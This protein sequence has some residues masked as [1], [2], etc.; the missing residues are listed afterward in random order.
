MSV[1]TMPCVTNRAVLF[2]LMAKDWRTF[3]VPVIAL[4][5]LGLGAYGYGL[6]TIYSSYKDAPYVP[7][8]SWCMAVISSTFLAT[9]ISALIAAAFGG[10]AI[11]GER[12]DRT[13][14]FVEILPVSRRQIVASKW[15]VTLM[16][17]I[18]TLALHLF[19]GLIAYVFYLRSIRFEYHAPTS[20]MPTQM[21]LFWFVPLLL[22]P[23]ILC[24]FSV[25]WLLGSFIKSAA[26]S[27]CVSIATTIAGC[28]FA[29]QFLFKQ[30]PRWRNDLNYEEIFV[31][32]GM[33]LI[34]AIPCLIL[35][36]LIYLKRVEP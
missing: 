5:V 23:F 12:A 31:P 8:T 11:A 15:L 2:T 18:A 9:A 22:T 1:A 3:R 14:T 6:V 21:D 25:A 35:G 28:L 33:A 30:L 13:A 36:T 7:A 17:F 34:F 20:I 26:I 10:I 29:T 19:I 32:A 27:A 24:L 16:I 4:V